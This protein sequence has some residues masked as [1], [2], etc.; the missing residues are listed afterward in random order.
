MRKLSVLSIACA[1]S[2]GACS[3]DPTEPVNGDVITLTQSQAVAL[4]AKVES[5]GAQDATLRALSDT[6][7][8]V[9]K[10]GAQVRRIDV[11][12]DLG[13]GSYWA[14]SLQMFA[15]TT[16]TFHVIAFDDPS[17]PT[18]F[19]ILGGAVLGSASPVNS[20]TGSIGTTGT[21][22]LTGHLLTTSGTAVS[23]WH[24]SAGTA[25]FVVHPTSQACPAF[26]GPGNCA[27]LTMDATFNFTSSV[28]DHN[29]SATGQRTAS[30]A[31]EGIP[32]V[33]LSP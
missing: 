11:T 23:A 16:S 18:R 6:V 9:I 30:G 5:F 24:V 17:N 26:V 15:G 14:V 21:T 28:P 4:V 1:L 27:S 19:I 33:R 20:A 25:S 29:G 2:L 12:S 22:S 31:A 32:G 8:V 7:D 3:D 10:A 13:N